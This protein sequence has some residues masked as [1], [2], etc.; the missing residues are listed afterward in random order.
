MLIAPHLNKTPDQTPIATSKDLSFEGLLGNTTLM[1]SPWKCSS[2]PSLKQGDIYS[3]LQLLFHTSPEQRS[4]SASEAAPCPP[5]H[6]S[7]NP[8]NCLLMKEE[9]ISAVQTY[10]HTHTHKEIQTKF[11]W[12]FLLAGQGERTR[13]MTA[14]PFCVVT[15][16]FP[17]AGQ[18]QSP[19]TYPLWPVVR[20]TRA[21]GKKGWQW[22][23]LFLL[24][25]ICTCHHG[26]C[27]ACRASLRQK[28][29]C[30]PS[31]ASHAHSRHSL[32]YSHAC[33]ARLS[34]TTQVPSED[35]MNQL[36]FGGKWDLT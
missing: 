9:W 1:P 29:S 8:A 16:P 27:P 4:Q 35:V 5:H 12:S 14:L 19:L 31:W 24:Q 22:M 15:V 10:T 11:K 33:P 34:G 20:C 2:I 25:S 32:S 21:P 28:P 6:S 36:C 7:G 3:T 18:T 17:D 23:L 30:P 26:M 13:W